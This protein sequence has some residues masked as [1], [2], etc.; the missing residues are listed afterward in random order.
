MELKTSLKDYTESEFGAL[1]D[2]IWA[3]DLP[4]QEH[5]QMINHFDQI[6]GHPQGADL[7][8]YPDK[9]FGSNNSSMVVFHVRAWHQKQGVAAFK[10]EAISAV[11]HTS[12]PTNPWTRQLANGQKITA[13][14]AAL[15]Q[16]VETA[17]DAF[18]QC[19][20]QSQSVPLEIF[21][22][23]LRIRTLEQ[24][25]HGASKAVN[26]FK[27]QQMRIEFARNDAQRSLTYARSEQAQWQSVVHQINATYDD[28]ITKLAVINQRHRE[29]HAEA[30]SILKSGQVHLVRAR[31]LAGVSPA[32]SAHLMSAS[33]ASLDRHCD[34][35]LHAGPPP[36]ALSQQVDLKKAIRSTV[37]EMA[38][39]DNSNESANGRERAAIL[40]FEFPS[41]AD[42][43]VYGVS[44][45]LIELLP[46]EGTDW[47][48]L[49]ASNGD[50]EA[51]FRMHSA[52]VTA[53][54]G[55]MFDGLREVE[56]LTQVYVASTPKSLVTSGVRVRVRAARRGQQPD[57]FV[58][59]GDGAASPTVQWVAPPGNLT[60]D[61]SVA[62][63]TRRLG[64][65][66]SSRVPMLE[67]V[68]GEEGTS[69][70]DYIV[71]FPAESGFD[72]LYLMFGNRGEYP[73]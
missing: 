8:F 56:A 66:S 60:V 41:R 15:G 19:I 39:R 1:V 71:V 13:D 22:Q 58:F 34:V 44:V 63:Q 9:R 18:A 4:K 23:E 26:R 21:A 25:Q 5:D 33:T 30:E 40:Q 17:F 62:S 11:T 50:I 61:P 72:P 37:A 10:P 32:Q 46:L 42:T 45:P 16:I 36:L 52:V 64:F 48:R 3:V 28:F 55:T 57:S 49:A 70:D 27:Y 68:I 59:T 24:S 47:Q 73:V 20:R 69:F 29:L 7:L 43:Q 53:T 65:I 31:T 54:P 2:K 67:R 38:W 14:M 51:P 6:A 12:G 35:L